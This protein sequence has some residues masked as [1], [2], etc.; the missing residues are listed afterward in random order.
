MRSK[1]KLYLYYEAG[2]SFKAIHWINA[3][4]NLFTTIPEC[5]FWVLSAR[6]G[7]Y[8]NCVKYTGIGASNGFKSSLFDEL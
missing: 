1:G 8:F 4:I 2:L 3:S 6:I 7:V 5:N